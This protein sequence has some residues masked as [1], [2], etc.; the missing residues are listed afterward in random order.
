MSTRTMSLTGDKVATCPTCEREVSVVKVA[1]QGDVL[2]T[3]DINP[4]MRMICQ[5]SKTEAV[6]PRPRT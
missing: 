3:H 6:N 2:A 4:W 1:G 5:G